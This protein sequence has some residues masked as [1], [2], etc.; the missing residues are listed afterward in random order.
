[1]SSH[2]NSMVVRAA[3]LDEVLMA[4][5]SGSSVDAV[6]L[7]AVDGVR[8]GQPASICYKSSLAD[9]NSSNY[10]NSQVVKCL[11][12]GGTMRGRQG[13]IKIWW[14]PKHST[15]YVGAPSR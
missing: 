10:I 1:M 13:R 5:V 2:D 9:N 11:Q 12:H 15:V 4:D 6:D 14:C 8:T 3:V 7:T